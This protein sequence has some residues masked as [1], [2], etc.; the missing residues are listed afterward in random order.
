MRSIR[1]STSSI[2][3]PSEQRDGATELPRNFL[4]RRSPHFGRH[5]TNRINR[6]DDAQWGQL[7]PSFGHYRLVCEIIYPQPVASLAKPGTRIGDSISLPV[8]A[9]QDIKGRNGTDDGPFVTRQC[10]Q[11]RRP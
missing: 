1:T 11:R 10:Q 9:R 8:R 5:A 7:R 6:G 2:T 3:W 4:P